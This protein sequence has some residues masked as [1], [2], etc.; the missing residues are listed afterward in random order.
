MQNK[1]DLN[2]HEFGLNE[3]TETEKRLRKFRTS[4]SGVTICFMYCGSDGS[5]FFVLLILHVYVVGMHACVV[6]LHMCVMYMHVL[7]V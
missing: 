4:S 6:W 7:M 2:M 1:I 3:L 5:V